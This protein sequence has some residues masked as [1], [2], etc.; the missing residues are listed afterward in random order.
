MKTKWKRDLEREGG[1][2]RLGESP[3]WFKY[4]EHMDSHMQLHRNIMGGVK[5]ICRCKLQKYWTERQNFV[6]FLATRAPRG[7]TPKVLKLV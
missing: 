1:V 6:F 5:D 4:E 3:E 7:E 2:I